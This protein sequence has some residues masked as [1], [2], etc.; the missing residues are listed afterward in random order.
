MN[1]E[2]GLGVSGKRS[3]D[4]MKGKT[5]SELKESLDKAFMTLIA[6]WATLCVF[7][8]FILFSVGSKPFDAAGAIL[9]VAGLIVTLVDRRR[10][11]KWAY[12]FGLVTAL[13]GVLL[14]YLPGILVS[15]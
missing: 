3:S 15:P 2:S 7:L 9:V 13:I 12:S 8:W 5:S 6:I 14:T 4:A 10:P 1:E 11:I